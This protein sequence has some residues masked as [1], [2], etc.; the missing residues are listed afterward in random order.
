M[1]ALESASQGALCGDQSSAQATSFAKASAML[2]GFD[3][4]AAGSSLSAEVGGVLSAGGLRSFIASASNAAVANEA[5]HVEVTKSVPGSL[6]A[7]LGDC[8]AAAMPTSISA[9]RPWRDACRTPRFP[10]ARG[11]RA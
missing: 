1:A 6:V 9:Q 10:Q 5:V 7:N 4:D 2:N 8:S 3:A 11:W